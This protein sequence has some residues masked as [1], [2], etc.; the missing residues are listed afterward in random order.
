M[1]AKLGDPFSRPYSQ[2]SSSSTANKGQRAY[3]PAPQG[4][5]ATVRYMTAAEEEDLSRKVNNL[6]IARQQVADADKTIAEGKRLQEEAR[7]EAEKAR[8]GMAQAKANTIR[9]LEGAAAGLE[10]ML[11][12]IKNNPTATQKIEAI[13][14]K[15]LSAKD[16]LPDNPVEQQKLVLALK[17]ESAVVIQSLQQA[18]K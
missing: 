7:A 15:I 3:P 6:L 2:Q 4:Q 16:N 11:G 5:A 14:Q 17:Q 10:K 9:G 18:K 8:A 1:T 12:A 13:R